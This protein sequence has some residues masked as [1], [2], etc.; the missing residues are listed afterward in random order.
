[1]RSI[2]LTA[3]AGAVTLCGL[4]FMPLRAFADHRY[5]GYHVYYGRHWSVFHGWAAGDALWE[6]YRDSGVEAYKAGRYAEAEKLLVLALRTAQ[7]DDGD[8]LCV[9]QSLNDLALLFDA[10]GKY[11][12]PHPPYKKSIAIS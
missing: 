5:H 11:A 9:A 6:S 8:G 10:Q 12:Q 3:A 1:M 7:A 2:L 4:A